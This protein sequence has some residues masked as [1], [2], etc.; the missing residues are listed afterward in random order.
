MLPRKLCAKTC[1][2]ASS[3]FYVMV[4]AGMFRTRITE[5]AV[6]TFGVAEKMATLPGRLL[7]RPK[8]AKGAPGQ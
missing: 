5:R 8:P 3:N 7:A 4:Q 2:Y 6:P 1:Q